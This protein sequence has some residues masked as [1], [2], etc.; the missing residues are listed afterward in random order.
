MRVISKFKDYYDSAIGYGGIDNTTVYVRALEEST[1]EKFNHKF[2]NK[3]NTRRTFTYRNGDYTWGMVS[4]SLFFCGKE[5]PYYRFDLGTDNSVD[6]NGYPTNNYGKSIVKTFFGGVHDEEMFE[7]FTNKDYIKS[8]GRIN[9]PEDYFKE[10]ITTHKNFHKENYEDV[11]LEY[12]SPI[13]DVRKSTRRDEICVTVNPILSDLGFARI[14]N[15]FEAFQEINMYMNGPLCSRQE[16]EPEPLS[17]KY[18][19]LRHGMDKWSFRRK[20]SK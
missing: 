8:S 2:H 7:L 3:H 15:P 10:T 4:G 17:E 18:S 19:V 5:Y 14:I 9:T 12:K 6:K 16:V 1:V 20:S 13:I 11:H